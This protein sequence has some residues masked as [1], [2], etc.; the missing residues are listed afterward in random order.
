MTSTLTCILPALKQG[1]LDKHHTTGWSLV[2]W[3]F[4]IT[5]CVWFLS[6]CSYVIFVWTS[7]KDRMWVCMSIWKACESTAP[8]TLMSH[9]LNTA[10][11]YHKNF[12]YKQ[13]LN[14]LTWFEDEELWN[15]NVE[16]P[17]LVQRAI[18]RVLTELSIQ[19]WFISTKVI[20]RSA[21][22]KRLCF[23]KMPWAG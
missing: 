13:G 11:C 17:L 2:L 18:E 22:W 21:S 10:W 7:P 14:T 5:S 4:I 16:T 15:Y 12:G 8:I 19:P 3:V 6:K 20:S 23:N 1:T 9:E